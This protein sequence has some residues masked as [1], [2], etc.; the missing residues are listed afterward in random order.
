MI[1]ELWNSVI[2]NPLLN[3]LV[4]I[5]SVVGNYGVAILILTIL[6][7]LVTLP[8]SMQQMKSLKAQQQLAPEVQALQ[9]KY[10]KDR[11]RLAQEQMKLYKEKGINPLGGCLPMLIP[12]PLFVAFYQVVSSVMSTQPEQFMDLAHRLLPS[13][14]AVVP[15]SERFLWLNLSR[16]DPIYIL[17]LLSVV[18]TWVQ[19]K[20]MAT[21]SGTDAQAQSMNQTMGIMMPLFM[22]WIT[23]TFA[24]GLALYWVMFNVVGIIQQYF[25]TGWG[26]LGKRLPDSIL[27]V[28]P[29]PVPVQKTA[30]V[31]EDR[32]PSRSRRARLDQDEET[33]RKRS[34]RAQSAAAVE[35]TGEEPV[36]QAVAPATALP[37]KKATR[38]ARKSKQ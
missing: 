18:T 36:E 35:E 12:W 13:L 1:T 32:R 33:P 2:V 28:L 16:P 7:K 21:A 10:A 38:Q 14:A 25:T 6:I 19:Q 27:K 34:T 4:F 30:P 23:L 29:G 11:E 20:M 37:S 5:Y 3:V 22:G 26:E 24:S 17:P 31:V 8:F 15:V 9:K